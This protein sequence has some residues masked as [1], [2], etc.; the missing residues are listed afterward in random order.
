MKITHRHEGDVLVM[1]LA[2]KMAIGEGDAVARDAIA[3]ALGEGEKKILLDMKRVSFL[4]SSGVGELVAAHTSAHNGG[5]VI[6]LL[7][8][9]PRVGEVLKSTHL[10]GIFEHYDDEKEALDS[11][12]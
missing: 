8:L 11:F 5:A 2:G 3:K 7:K 10:I 9:A 12:S 6:K 4:D 1:K